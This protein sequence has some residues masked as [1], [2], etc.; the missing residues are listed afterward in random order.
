MWRSMLK[1]AAATAVYAP[2]HSALA[3]PD[4]KRRVRRAVGD[5]AFDGLY[6]A[7]YNA[8]AIF[9]LDALA[10]YARRLPDTELYEAEGATRLALRAGQAAGL[11]TM[12]WAQWHVGPPPSGRARAPTATARW[13]PTARSDSRATR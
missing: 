10:A 1:M 13:P 8:E 11:A 12:G 7:A 2:A 5:R 9:G 6:W 3:S 4:T